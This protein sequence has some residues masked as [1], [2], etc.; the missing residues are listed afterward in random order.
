MSET[1]EVVTLPQLIDEFVESTFAILVAANTMAMSPSRIGVDTSAGVALLAL[2][3]TWSARIEEIVT[4]CA[5]VAVPQ[6]PTS[7]LQKYVVGFVI[8][9]VNC[10]AIVKSDLHVWETDAARSAEEARK[11][12]KAQHPSSLAK[13]YTIQWVAAHD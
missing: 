13:K 2:K 8:E 12:F 10:H 6:T 3:D 11:L 4:I 5:S 7:E 1:Q 9:T